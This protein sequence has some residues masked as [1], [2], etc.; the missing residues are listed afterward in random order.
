MKGVKYNLTIKKPNDEY[1][2]YQNIDMNELCNKIKIIMKELYN[3]D[4]LKLN[5]QI[6]YNLMKRPARARKLLREFIKVE[7]TVKN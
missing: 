3:I 2:L 1:Y 6:I 4:N 5:N 7:K